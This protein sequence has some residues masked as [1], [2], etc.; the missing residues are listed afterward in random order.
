M[1]STFAFV[2]LSA[3]KADESVRECIRECNGLRWRQRSI[4]VQAAQESFMQR[5]ARERREKL[6]N[7][8]TQDHPSYNPMQMFKDRKKDEGEEVVEEKEDR[9]TKRKREDQDSGYSPVK[10]FKGRDKSHAETRRPETKFS[11]DQRWQEEPRRTEE[12]PLSGTVKGG[13]VYFDDD[14]EDEGEKE[15]EEFKQFHRKEEEAPPRRRRLYHSSGSED[16]EREK[17]RP[18][19]VQAK[20]QRMEKPKR[21][22]QTE[23]HVATRTQVKSEAPQISPKN[24]Q[25]K[26]EIPKSLPSRRRQQY[27]SS[28]EDEEEE[29][30]PK[31]NRKTSS[32]LLSKLSN[33]QSDVWGADDDDDEGD[34]KD[35]LDNQKRLLGKKR[36]RSY[37]DESNEKRILSL[38]R[39]QDEDK[40]RQ[41]KIKSALKKVDD[42]VANNKIVFSD[43]EEDEEKAAKGDKLKAKKSSLFQYSDE[44]E[45]NDDGEDDFK[46]RSQFQGKGGEKLLALQSRIS[47]GDDRFKIDSRFKEDEDG[48]VG[49]SESGAEGGG[50][51]EELSSKQER[52]RNLG[53]LESVVG[54]KLGE[55][56]KRGQKFTDMTQRRYD[57]EAEGH[58]DMELKDEESEGEE[59]L[60]RKRKRQKSEA[61]APPPKVEGERT[62]FLRKE[63]FV[64]GAEGAGK[65]SSSTF[66]F[67][68]GASNMER[69]DDKDAKEEQILKKK[70]GATRLDFLERNPFK[71]DSSSSED[72]GEEDGKVKE[73][74]S[75]EKDDRARREAEL[76]RR[77]MEKSSSSD[78]NP[79]A[80]RESFF[81]K[82]GD[83]RFAE[84]TEPLSTLKPL[85]EAREAF[86]GGRRAE[87]RAI[88]K[89]R[90]DRAKRRKQ[91]EWSSSGGGPGGGA[92]A[93]SGKKRKF[94]RPRKMVVTKKKK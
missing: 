90:L 71:Y 33:F 1:V 16:E 51:D 77:L 32:S 28:S 94:K 87:L 52:E 2:N 85:D 21:L 82:A 79:S 89:K 18:V 5:L 29:Q 75:A 84:I 17:R 11:Y 25:V 4:R 63:V 30:T 48:E 41:D 6:A 15:T 39:K 36:T 69:K 61:P 80:V 26:N 93:S 56:K 47:A 76:G 55:T 27:Y 9:V 64:P 73:K 3:E 53:I 22:P 70:K 81:L 88:L 42:V 37:T 38:K 31:P 91:R 74:S 35:N 13:C 10:A 68:F 8:D 67:G 19:K 62:F 40:Q 46:V 49:D 24:T 57:P 34:K 86:D 65:S 83:P 45:E 66:S 12:G 59:E 58:Q 20:K 78:V 54:K 72:E 92:E 23:T 44:D 14:E 7:F 50:D 60:E 43:A